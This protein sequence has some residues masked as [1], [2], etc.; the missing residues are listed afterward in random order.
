MSPLLINI[1]R[2]QVSEEAVVSS[3]K[4]KTINCPDTLGQTA[5]WIACARLTKDPVF[6]RPVFERIAIKLLEKGADPNATPPGAQGHSALWLACFSLGEKDPVF[7]RIAIKLLEKGADPKAAPAEQYP[8]IL[9]AA[10]HGNTPLLERFVQLV[11]VD[12][13]YICDGVTPLILAA[14]GGHFQACKLLLTNKADPNLQNRDGSTALHAVIQ[15]KDPSIGVAKLLLNFGAELLP[16][17]SGITPLHQIYTKESIDQTSHI[18][19]IMLLDKAT[20]AILD[21]QP[22]PFLSYATAYGTAEVVKKTLE[23]GAD[24]QSTFLVGDRP[25]KS[26]PIFSAVHVNNGKMLQYLI[27]K[28]ASVDAQIGGIGLFCWAAECNAL[29]ALTYLLTLPTD[30]NQK[31][32]IGQSACHIACVKNHLLFLER[33]LADPRVDPTLTANDGSTAL[34]SAANSGSLEACELLCHKLTNY[35]AKMTDGATS[36]ML[37]AQNGHTLVVR[38]LLSLGA[39]Y[40]HKK[41]DGLNAIA[42]A[43][44]YGHLQTVEEF[45]E[46]GHYNEYEKKLARSMCWMSINP[47]KGEKMLATLYDYLEEVE[48]ELETRLSNLH[49]QPEPT[50]TTTSI[51]DSKKKT[52]AE[53]LEEQ[54]ANMQIQPDST[55]S[56]KD[57]KDVQKKPVERRTTMQHHQ[58]SFRAAVTSSSTLVSSSS[59]TPVTSGRAFLKSELGLTD[60]QITRL[61]KGDM[62][63]NELQ[64]AKNSVREVP[65][66]YTWANGKLS[67][68]MP[69]V[70]PI[71]S[72]T[73]PNC[74]LYLDLKSLEKYGFNNEILLEKFPIRFCAKQNE[75]G[76]KTLTENIPDVF[77]TIGDKKIKTPLRYELKVT[78]S[79]CRILGYA[80]QEGGKTLIVGAIFIKNH[81][82]LDLSAF[83]NR[84]LTLSLTSHRE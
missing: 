79:G 2:K 73:T 56:V 34:H 55:S 77:V 60:D 54:L 63:P 71:E 59:S 72:Q 75:Q 57:S 3:I 53:M 6:E 13:R 44:R 7:E 76:I 69:E 78:S 19:S 81:D 12:T 15:Q 8:P 48:S 24:P 82:R 11:P 47:A 52:E 58:P 66:T 50:A 5:L 83:R 51:E 17:L 14:Y 30:P 29:D 31:N 49:I 25:A 45:L 68:Q 33:L 1:L 23:K 39:D 20:K 27:E 36:L 42:L 35:D 84:K 80:I 16:D 67:T 22:S 4:N 26:L 65:Y 10:Q 9:L 37:A 41:N 64:P 18:L 28:G 46:K 32:A 40:R 62:K 38:Y 74:F 70:M 61:K 21:Q 43:C